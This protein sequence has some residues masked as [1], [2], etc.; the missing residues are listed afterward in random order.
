MLLIFQSSN[1]PIIAKIR[2][3]QITGLERH[4]LPYENINYDDVA[5]QVYSENLAFVTGYDE[6]LQTASRSCMVTTAK[7]RWS[8]FIK[9]FAFKK[10]FRYEEQ[11]NL[12][13]VYYKCENLSLLLVNRWLLD[14]SFFFQ[15]AW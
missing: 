11:F 7:E 14:C 4:Q 10:F 6:A 15:S 8:E 3:N 1:N 13:Y 2:K 12:M 9:G 5:D